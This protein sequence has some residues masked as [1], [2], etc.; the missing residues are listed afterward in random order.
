MAPGEIKNRSK[1]VGA[2]SMAIAALV[3]ATA[4]TAVF[5]TP[6][7]AQ[8]QTPA[9]SSLLQ[10][11]LNEALGMT[12]KTSDFAYRITVE[13]DEAEVSIY[14]AATPGNYEVQSYH[15]HSE[16]DSSGTV[17]GAHCHDEGTSS[18]VAHALP[19]KLVDRSGYLSAIGSALSIFESRIA[20]TET[21]SELKIWQHGDDMTLRITSGN[22]TSPAVNL[23]SC[24]LHGANYDC[25]RTR[26][27]GPNEPAN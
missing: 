20:K 13:T 12:A 26:K 1:L 18:P 21:I 23:F 15:C 7:I 22:A 25:H 10:L 19:A 9:N 4:V 17:A 27:A 6:T 3:T 5:V 11:A 14:Q 24:H 8:G 2:T 16:L